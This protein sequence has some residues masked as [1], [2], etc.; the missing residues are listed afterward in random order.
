MVFPI[1]L[2]LLIP[3][4]SAFCFFGFGNCGQNIFIVQRD[5]N[6]TIIDQNII[7]DGNGVTWSQINAVVPWADSNV[8]VDLNAFMTELTFDSNFTV[9]INNLDLNN[10]LNYSKMDTNAQTACSNL[11]YLA[12]NGTCQTIPT[13]TGGLGTFQGVTST[14]M[15]GNMTFDGNAGYV[16][17]NNMCDGN[18]TG[19]HWCTTD[20]IKATIDDNN[21]TSF[22]TDLTAWNMEGNPGFL[23][24]SND[25]QGMTDNTSTFLGA[26]WEFNNSTGGAGFLTNCSVKKVLACCG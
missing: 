5:V 22:T 3:S 7:Q 25:C 16:A 6:Q 2:L 4:V 1:L 19:S 21:H 20:E 13:A 11:E 9:S 10:S 26:F 18:F 15:D 23:S 24:N 17:A 8:D 14:A 12:G